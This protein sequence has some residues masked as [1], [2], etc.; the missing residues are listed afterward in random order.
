MSESNSPHEPLAVSRKTASEL[1]DC[2]IDHVD[3]LVSRGQ[4]E[5]I[6][7]GVRKVAVTWASLKALVGGS[8]NGEAA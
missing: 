1:L 2:S 4:L 8:I 5:L 7:I 6:H 3:D